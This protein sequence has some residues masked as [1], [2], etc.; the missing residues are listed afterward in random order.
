MDLPKWSNGI[1]KDMEIGTVPCKLVS[2][3]KVKH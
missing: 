1:N 3:S 2:E